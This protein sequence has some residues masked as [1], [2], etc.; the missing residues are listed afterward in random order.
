MQK[1]WRETNCLTILAQIPSSIQKSG[2]RQISA[3]RASAVRAIEK[4]QL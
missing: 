3:R 2:L 1:R 4:V